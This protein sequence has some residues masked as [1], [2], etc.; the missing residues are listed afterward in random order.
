MQAT[1]VDFAK[2]RVVFRAW[3][4]DGK[5]PID[6]IVL[7]IIDGI[8][9]SLR[10]AA[11]DHCFRRAYFTERSLAVWIRQCYDLCRICH[12]YLDIK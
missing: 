1:V 8:G 3:H 9:C 2:D 11:A 4:I 6:R 7:I 5:A 10:E 12:K